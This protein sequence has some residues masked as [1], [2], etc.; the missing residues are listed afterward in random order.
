M[1]III[2]YT[3]VENGKRNEKSQFR[4]TQQ[5]RWSEHNNR[6]EFHEKKNVQMELLLKLYFFFPSSQVKKMKKR[7][8]KINGSDENHE[9]KKKDERMIASGSKKGRLCFILFCKTQIICDDNF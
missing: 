8:K 1:A 7:N 3:N 9:S 5:S 4:E 2:Q 6:I